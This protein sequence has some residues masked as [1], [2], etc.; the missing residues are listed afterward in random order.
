MNSLIIGTYILCINMI[1]I[2]AAMM[3]HSLRTLKYLSDKDSGF[4]NSA[5][6]VPTRYMHLSQ[7]SQNIRKIKR[8]LDSAVEMNKEG[9]ERTSNKESVNNNGVGCTCGA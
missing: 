1:T 8:K 9:V 2:H 3:A 4:I 5:N 6:P 7:N